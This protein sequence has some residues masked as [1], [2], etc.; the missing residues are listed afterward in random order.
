MT[1]DT[2]ADPVAEGLAQHFTYLVDKIADELVEVAGWIR[3]RGH[4]TAPG[5]QLDIALA[6][7]H[8]LT[9]TS[10]NLPCE[11]LVRAAVD[12]DRHR[13]VCGEEFDAG[14]PCVLPPGHRGWHAS[15]PT[16]SEQDGPQGGAVW[17]PNRD[18]S[19]VR[20]SR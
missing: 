17:T 2:N 20:M 12:V 9:A 13:A 4:S 8:R 11:L 7:V 16:Y 3:Q 10:P 1:L 14:R 6:I 18:D 19:D 5:R 15:A